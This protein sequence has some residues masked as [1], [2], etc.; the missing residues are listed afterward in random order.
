VKV[1]FRV[2]ASLVIGSGHLMRCLTLADALRSKGAQ[3]IF[4]SR[5]HVGHLHKTVHERGY[6]LISLGQVEEVQ[7]GVESTSSY[8]DWLGVEP[9]RD[10]YETRKNLASQGVDWLVVDHYGL[11]ADWEQCLRPVC[12]RI[13][14][15][16]DLANRKHEVDLLLDQNLGKVEEDYQ[17]L[18]SE[19]CEL[20]LG[21]SYALLRPEFIALRSFSLNRRSQ[22]RLRKLLIT[23]GGVDLENATEAVL[24]ALNQC[25]FVDEIEVTVVMG[26]TAPW[27]DQVRELTRGLS[28]STQLMVNVNNMAELMMDADLAI[29]AAGSTSWERCCLGLPTLQLVIADNQRPIASALSRVGAAHLVSHANLNTSLGFSINELLQD[30]TKLVRMSNISA[31]V[32]DGQGAERVV[33]Y[34][35]EGVKQ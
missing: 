19:S 11:G 24:Q 12:T 30:P 21:P 22:G 29:G 26:S 15:I 4:L 25:G 14:A 27:L 13:M 3:C 2:D 6:Q 1:A 9:E 16:D 34:L 23:M 5:N 35:C 31:N 7:I 20:L 33:Q 28:F 8:A 18:V 32:T 10:A 17:G